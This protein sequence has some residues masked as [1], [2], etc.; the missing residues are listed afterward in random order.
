MNIPSSNP[1][2]WQEGIEQQS[3]FSKQ[4]KPTKIRVSGASV[5]PPSPPPQ[6]PV[7]T[8]PQQKSRAKV[9]WTHDCWMWSLRVHIEWSVRAPPVRKRQSKLSWPKSPRRW[10]RYRKSPKP[11]GRYQEYICL[12]KLSLGVKY[13]AAKLTCE[14]YAEIQAC[15]TTYDS[16]Y[17]KLR[18]IT[19]ADMAKKLGLCTEQF[20]LCLG[21]GWSPDVIRVEFGLEEIAIIDLSRKIEEMGLNEA[22]SL[23]LTFGQQLFVAGS[24]MI[25]AE[26]IAECNLDR[27]FSYLVMARGDMKWLLAFAATL[28]KK[29]VQGHPEQLEAMKL[30]LW[31]WM[32]CSLVYFSG[33][34]LPTTSNSVTAITIMQKRASEDSHNVPF[35]NRKVC[36]WTDNDATEFSRPMRQNSLTHLSTTCVF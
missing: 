17:Q 33:L 15:S 21:L 4:T 22:L 18:S 9:V 19:V 16:W 29:C 14:T 10:E 25:L 28:K 6:L 12:T 30:S 11:N 5:L 8:P 3:A 13:I 24:V 27:L 32:Y 20:A 26:L 34:L 1:P 36:A 2:L 31:Y 35:R 23:M 7:L